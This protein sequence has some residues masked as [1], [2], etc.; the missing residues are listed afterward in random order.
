VVDASSNFLLSGSADSSIHV[1]SIP[2]LL[3]FSSPDTHSP[4]HTL[5]GHRSAI[6][7]L[8]IGHSTSSYNIVVSASKD[9]TAIIW[10]YQNN[11]LLRTVLLPSTPLCLALDPADRAV[12]AG[13]E[14]GSVQI[15]HFF[16]DA[17]TASA[18]E[19]GDKTKNPLYD[20]SQA[21]L[22]VQPP[23]STRWTPPTADTGAALCIS[24]S[25]DGSSLTTGHE[26]GK[27][28]FW[29]IPLG[30]YNS[31]FAPTSNPLPGPVTNLVALPVSGFPSETTPART[32]LHAIVKPKHG[33]FENRDLDGAVPG[34][35]KLTGQFTTSFPLPHFS[36]SATTSPSESEFMQALSHPSFPP[37]LL[38]K[39]LAEFSSWT[40]GKISQPAPA[41]VH[42]TVAKPDNSAEFVSLDAPDETKQPTLEQKNK[43]LEEEV[44][45]LRKAQRET[46]RELSDLKKKVGGKK[47]MVVHPT[48]P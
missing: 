1:W 48:I 2:S 4:L 32:K 42:K 36:A 40:P 39:S 8:A 22:P 29:D 45:A 41:P 18:I 30:R 26:N 38:A 20:E 15:I 10:D 44:K 37:D 33:A 23:A 27:I 14:D 28:L 3:S 24:L 43:Q 11:T 34:D 19:E 13:Y 7:A 17:F 21:T 31:T 5:T 6:T 12:Y 25:Y 35:Y 16:S 9:N 46:L 47:Q